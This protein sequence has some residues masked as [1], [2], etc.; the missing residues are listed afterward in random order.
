MTEINWDT[1][2]NLAREACKFAYAPYSGYPVG[3]AGITD[4]GMLVSG[5]NVENA[6]T[7][8]GLCAECGMVSNLVRSG[9]GR[10]VAVA[11]VNGR[12]EPVAPCGRCR[13]LLYEHGGRELLVQ[14]PSGV[15]PMAEVL[16]DAFGP[17]D[18]RDMP[19]AITSP[20]P[21]EAR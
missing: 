6:S 5:C 15:R 1:L 4:T 3:A 13:Q 12:G 10:L 7:G 2:T 14:M 8:L 17:D 18:L 16:P 21:L 9:G 19:G 11:C 20:L